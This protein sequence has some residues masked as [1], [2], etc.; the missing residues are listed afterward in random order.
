MKEQVP[1]EIVTVS[2]TPVQNPLPRKITS[3]SELIIPTISP[4]IQPHRNLSFYLIKPK[5]KKKKINMYNDKKRIFLKAGVMRS[6]QTIKKKDEMKRNSPISL[7]SPSVRTSTEWCRRR[8]H[9]RRC[10]PRQ[11]WFRRWNWLGLSRASDEA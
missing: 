11:R 2:Y 9:S 5:K 10:R 4:L 6:D 7:N 8:E 1:S 3:H